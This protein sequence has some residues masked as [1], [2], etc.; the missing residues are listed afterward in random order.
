[1]TLSLGLLEKPADLLV[2]LGQCRQENETSPLSVTNPPVHE[3]QRPE[4][5]N[6]LDNNKA[7]EE[8]LH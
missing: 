1:M 6:A 5:Q 4:K 3:I 7:C 8:V 2:M